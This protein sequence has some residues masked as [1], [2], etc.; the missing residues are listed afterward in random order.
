MTV[1]EV[2]DELLKLMKRE[3]NHEITSAQA[4]EEMA[5][6]IARASAAL[7]EEELLDIQRATLTAHQMLAD[8]LSGAV[9]LIRE[10]ILAGQ[11]SL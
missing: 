7:T 9:S 8:E 5:A 1:N 2:L 3:A 6:I 10:T 11:S 4:T